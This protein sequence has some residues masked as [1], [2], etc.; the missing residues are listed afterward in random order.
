LRVTQYTAI[1]L[2]IHFVQLLLLFAFECDSLL[3]LHLH[4]H[5]GLQLHLA[6]VFTTLV[7]FSCQKLELF[8]HCVLVFD[9]FKL[10]KN[11]ETS[12]SFDAFCKIFINCRFRLHDD[13]QKVVSVL[14][15]FIII[16][17]KES[18][19]SVVFINELLLLKLWWMDN[20]NVIEKWNDLWF[21][22]SI[23]QQHCSH[24]CSKI[25][26]RNRHTMHSHLN[27]VNR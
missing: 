2:Y 20:W 8:D 12:L 17:F 10:Y 18:D 1:S 25:W 16:F 21:L 15:L 23:E 11:I 9:T 24:Q 26:I 5:L 22:Q 27:A 7:T 6:F 19:D 3:E 13:I 14:L 4:L